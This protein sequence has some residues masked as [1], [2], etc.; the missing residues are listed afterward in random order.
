[1]VLLP[2]PRAPLHCLRPACLA[3][4]S[5]YFRGGRCPLLLPLPSISLFW[6]VGR[7]F[8][9]SSSYYI[10]SLA[11]CC[12][13]FHSLSFPPARL[14][15]PRT[16]PGARE[17]D[18]GGSYVLVVQIIY[19]GRA[20]PA[21]S[22][23]SLPPSLPPLLSS[24]RAGLHAR[25]TTTRR[26]VP[27][28]LRPPLLLPARPRPPGT[29]SPPTTASAAPRCRARVVG[30][31]GPRRQEQRKEG[32]GAGHSWWLDVR[33]VLPVGSVSYVVCAAGEPCA[34]DE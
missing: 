1:M 28:L 22:I 14:L 16:S 31:R 27:P 12:F 7:S 29:G 11:R 18:G 4:P 21:H 3:S 15:V 25:R 34:G 17:R 33:R 13:C 20:L 26:V 8:L 19:K 24:A 6:S 5:Y 9:W 32:E 10:L 23:L 30:G 2:R